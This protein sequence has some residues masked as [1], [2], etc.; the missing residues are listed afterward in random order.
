M[1]HH[2]ETKHTHNGNLREKQKRKRK[3]KETEN[4]FKEVM[5]ENFPNL[6][7]NFNI[8]IQEVQMSSIKFNPNM[9]SPRHIT[10]KLPKH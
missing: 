7:E 4:I 1:G 10:I 6:G 9:S 8:Q 5:A 2:Q 3:R